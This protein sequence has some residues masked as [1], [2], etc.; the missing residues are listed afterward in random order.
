VRA[1]LALTTTLLGASGVAVVTAAPSEAAACTSRSGVTV[2]V[3]FGT[4]GGT[5]VGCAGTFGS[6][7][8]AL[9]SAGHSV[10]YLPKQPGMVCTID[11][12][13]N[14][15]NGAPTTAYWSYWRASP[16]GSWS[17]STVGA[18]ST[19]PEAGTVEGWAFGA[20]K[21][22]AVRPPS[23]PAATTSRPK[24]TTSTSHGSA[25]ATTSR[26]TARPSGSGGTAVGPRSAAPS[27]TA[28]TAQ[29]T[30]TTTG[31][32]SGS[33]TSATGSTSG[34]ATDSSE[35][36]VLS[37]TR[38]DAAVPASST[39]GGGGRGALVLTAVLVLLLAGGAGVVTW[40][41][42]GSGA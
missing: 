1:V 16:G 23:L 30:G 13:P 4:L 42:R 41:R 3:D 21:P 28:T 2:V 11:R 6:G 27:T 22:P 20:G 40:R 7:I 24:P 19:H 14:P 35:M 26:P 32:T 37:A 25:R 36:R 5:S 31:T 12:L 34:T 17:Y 33:D 38:T 9:G 10:T 39:S 18:G 8:A 29:T 15:C